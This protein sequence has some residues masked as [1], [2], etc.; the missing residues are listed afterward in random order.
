MPSSSPPCRADIPPAPPNPTTASLPHWPE[1]DRILL[2]APAIDQRLR[3]LAAII[4]ADYTG[5]PLTVLALLKG[6][7]ILFA[8]LLRHIPLRLQTECLS[9]S[10]YHGTRSSGHLRFDPASLPALHSRHVLILDDIYDTGLTLSQIR[11]TLAHTPGI[12]SVRACVLLD[13]Q[14][15]AKHGPPPE[16][17]GF[18]IANEFVVGYGLDYLENYRNLPFIATLRPE[19]L[20]SL[21]SASP[22]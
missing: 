5:Q 18:R 22:H 11:H 13:K 19:A 21:S 14:I 20:S 8:D 9:V 15:P 16:Y 2:D 7:F 4:T 12:L 1:I 17:I 3:Q 6:S 10:S